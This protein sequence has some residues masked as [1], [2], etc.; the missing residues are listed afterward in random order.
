MK[1]IREGKINDTIYMWNL[2]NDTNGLIYKT[3]RFTEIKNKLSFQR[4][5]EAEGIN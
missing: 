5:K 2:K 3:N 1:L 4:E